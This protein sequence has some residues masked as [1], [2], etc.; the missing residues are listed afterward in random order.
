MYP[1]VELAIAEVDN[2]FDDFFVIDDAVFE[3]TCGSAVR[4]GDKFVFPGVP[5]VPGTTVPIVDIDEERKCSAT[6]LDCRRRS[7]RMPQSDDD[8]SRHRILLS[9][10][11]EWYTSEY[12]YKSYYSNVYVCP[13]RGKLLL[14]DD[15]IHVVRV[16]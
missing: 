3:S 14:D 2:V 8:D 15:A 7:I 12:L 6:L 13:A 1:F 5:S 16:R 4:D 11:S 10:G 9:D